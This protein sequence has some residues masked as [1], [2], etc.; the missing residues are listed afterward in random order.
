MKV[1][2]VVKESKIPVPGL[3]DIMSKALACLGM[4]ALHCKCML[5]YISA[6][7]D[8]ILILIDKPL[9][10]KKSRQ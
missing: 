4:H 5:G 10:W 6:A 1:N 8:V 3:Y 2:K 7:S 9:K